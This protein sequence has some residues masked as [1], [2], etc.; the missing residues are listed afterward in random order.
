MQVTRRRRSLEAAAMQ[1]SERTLAMREYAK[2][3]HR[4]EP[5]AIAASP[6]STQRKSFETIKKMIQNKSS[7]YDTDDDS[8]SNTSL[9]CS[10]LRLG[11]AT[12]SAQSSA[13]T[14]M[15]FSELGERCC[16]PA[17]D[18]KPNGCHQSFLITPTHMNSDDWSS[19]MSHDPT[20]CAGTNT[21][22]PKRA[23]LNA[24]SRATAAAAPTLYFPP[25]QVSTNFNPFL[26]LPL[27]IP[28]RKARSFNPLVSPASSNLSTTLSL[29][30]KGSSRT[31]S[32]KDRDSHGKIL[33][34]RTGTS[35]MTPA[36]SNTLQLNHSRWRSEVTHATIIGLY[37]LKRQLDENDEINEMS[38]DYHMDVVDDELSLSDISCSSAES[39]SR[40]F[41]E[42]RRWKSELI[43]SPSQL[44]LSSMPQ[45]YSSPGRDRVT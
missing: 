38:K 2:A 34:M 8:D 6:H 27:S 15:S 30:R 5:V 13:S 9:P 20:R 26:P 22:S 40:L 16:S 25:Q 31:M 42:S 1:T 32:P 14:G 19:N 17:E 43:V 18:M 21:F 23:S 3:D 12:N 44:S 24:T 41:D 36:H 37:E 39:S 33:R 45:S 29:P 11:K 28:S 4:T 7:A 35:Q 10:F